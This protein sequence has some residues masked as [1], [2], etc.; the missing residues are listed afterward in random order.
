MTDRF[1][2]PYQSGPAPVTPIVYVKN[3]TM[4][5]YKLVTSNLKEGPPREDQLNKLGQDGWELAGIVTDSP[6]VYFYF[7]RLKD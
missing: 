3:K 7:K 6:F 4:W 5:E 1:R 2:S